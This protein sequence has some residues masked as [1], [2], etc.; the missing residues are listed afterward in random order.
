MNQLISD[1]NKIAIDSLIK[2]YKAN[3]IN[4]NNKIM[5]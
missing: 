2:H 5:S 4:G 1:K 3:K